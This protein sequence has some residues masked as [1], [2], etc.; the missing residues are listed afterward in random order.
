VSAN[1]SPV[2]SALDLIGHLIVQGDY[3]QAV[4]H[5]ERL[6][7]YLPQQAQQRAEVLSQLGI[8]HAM[9]Q[10]FRKSYEVLTEAL[11]FEPNNA[12][13]WYNR[14]TANRFALRLGQS[15]RDLEQANKL[16][17][18]SELREKYHE[19]L[20]VCRKMAQ[21]SIELRGPDFTLDQLIEQETLFQQGLQLMEAEKLEEAE[22]AFETSIAMGD[23]TGNKEF[24]CVYANYML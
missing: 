5:C 21:A 13:L 23:Y 9:L 19:E 10:N 12:E 24:T 11:T 3:Q 18:R 17:T 22:Q 4:T 1:A 8:A 7:N 20:Q 14:S 15:L 2:D 6:L 16:N